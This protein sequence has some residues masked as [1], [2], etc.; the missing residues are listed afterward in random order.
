MSFHK[1]NYS[2]NSVSINIESQLTM[3]IESSIIIDG[4]FFNI[5]LLCWLFQ[6]VKQTHK[7]IYLYAYKQL[8]F[9]FTYF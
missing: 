3:N 9:H 7:F 1:V 2:D 4:I 5:L 8:L 6:R